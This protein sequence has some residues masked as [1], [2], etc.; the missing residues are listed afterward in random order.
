MEFIRDGVM[1]RLPPLAA[2]RAFE[3]A[4]RHLSFKEAAAE[5]GVTPTAISHQIRLL[6]AHCGQPLF[7]RMPRPLALTQAGK[8]LY[9]VLHDGFTRFVAAFAALRGDGAGNVLKVTATNAFATRWLV[10]RLPRWRR[11]HP[12]LRLEI[13]GTDAV[14]DVRAGDADVALRY[15]R[16]RPKGLASETLLRDR[17]HVLGSP[18]LAG[19]ASLPMPPAALARLPLIACD[20]PAHD[21]HAPT[22]DHWEEEARKRGGVVPRMARLVSLSFREE[23][24]AIDAVLAGQGIGILSDVIVERELA[25]GRLVRLSDIDLPGYVLRGAWREGHGREHRIREFLAWIRQ[26]TRG[27]VS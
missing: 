2:L 23:P 17:F 21:R 18:A 6:E 27:D 9:P 25:D 19:P 5:L 15:G 12:T 13:I 3:A 11:L 24:H 8:E 7:R 10:P 26:E 1:D 4:A 20:W 16:A 14:L 22:W